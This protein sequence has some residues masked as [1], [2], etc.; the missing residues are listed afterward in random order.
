MAYTPTSWTPGVFGTEITSARL[1][2]IETGIGKAHAGIGIVHT[3][4]TSRADVVATLDAAEAIGKW[5]V[6]VFPPAVYDLGAG[7]SLNGYSAQIRGHGSG[8]NGS[9]ATGTVFHASSQAG[10]VLDF[11][12]WIAPTNMVGRVEHSGFMI[13]GSGSAD[14]TKANVGI[15]VGS[16]AS[17]KFRDISI[18]D[19]GGP[20][21]K[22]QPPTPGYA[23]YFCDFESIVLYTPVSAKANDVPYLHSIEANGNRFRGIGFRSISS[24]ADTGVSGAVVFEGSASYP[25]HDNLLDAWWFEF[26]HVPDTGTIVNLSANTNTIRDFQFFD[27][28]RESGATGTSYFRLLPSVVTDFGGNKITGLIPGD[29]NGGAT[30]VQYG[31]DVRQS[32]NA[33][34]GVKGYKGNNVLLAS[35]V[36]YTSVNLHGAQSGATSAGWVDSSGQTTNHLVDLVAM[37]QVLPASWPGSPAVAI[38]EFTANGSWTKTAG[39][40]TVEVICIGAGAGGGSGRRGASGTVCGGGGGGGGGVLAHAVFAAADLGSTVSVAIGTG[41]AGGAAVTADATNGNSGSGGG[42]TAFGAHLVAVGGLAGGGGTTSGGSAGASPWT[43]GSAP[44]M[45]GGS[46]GGAGAVGTSAT[47]GVMGPSGGA[48]G[49]GISATPA[50]FNGGAGAT[51]RVG[52]GTAGAAGVVDTTTPTAGTPPTVRGSAGQAPGG[53]AA[54]ITTAAQAGAAA[55]G[56]GAGGGGGGASLNGNNSGAGGQ[57]GP[58]Y[59]LVITH[60]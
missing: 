58:G 46:V 16:A 20:C 29:N 59:C 36:G 34:H 33:I 42:Q 13:K 4:G 52:G 40:T 18:R 21:L 8:M 44:A 25:S 5:T 50:A 32:R 35:G 15:R 31:V 37:A 54:S 28:N 22:L 51:T 12:G 41:G 23:C 24:S 55:T 57:G 26:L 45:S 39:A 1:N 60:F 48:G 43:G 10:P 11:T 56:Y 47:P 30:S 53:G 7:L 2:N 14:A 3:G 17:T 19:T 6:V 9:T 49:G 27:I 38:A